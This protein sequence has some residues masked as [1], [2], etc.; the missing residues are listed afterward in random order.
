MK[1]LILILAV[2]VTLFSCNKVDNF[3]KAIQ[4]NYEVR[5]VD[6]K[7]GEVYDTYIPS[8]AEGWEF[9]ITETHLDGW[10]WWNNTYEV[11]DKGVLYA[12]NHNGD[13]GEV[14]IDIVGDSLL[15]RDYLG[16]VLHLG[17]K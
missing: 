6:H 10:H 5:F 11:L 15:V 8:G 7:G 17:R 4:G 2:G 13:G 3:H 12:P 9:D 14:H 16:N 1:N